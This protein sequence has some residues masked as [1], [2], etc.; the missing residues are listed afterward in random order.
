MSDETK[1]AEKLYQNRYMVDEG[2]P[3][4]RLAKPDAAPSDALRTLAKICPAG[5]YSE[6]KATG[7]VEIVADGCMECGTCR[8]LC[9]ETGELEWWYP[10][11]GFGI[12]YKFG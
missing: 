8:I 6:D 10:R 7:K 12:A 9:A 3:H 1:V 4:I 11:G 5:C 2:K